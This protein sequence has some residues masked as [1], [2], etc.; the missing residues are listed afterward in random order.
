MTTVVSGVDDYSMFLVLPATIFLHL[1]LSQLILADRQK[2][3]LIIVFAIGIYYGLLVFYVRPL[4]NFLR[5]NVYVGKD[6]RYP[7]GIQTEWCDRA[8]QLSYLY[9]MEEQVT[10]CYTAA[11]SQQCDNNLCEKIKEGYGRKG[12]LS[13]L[14]WQRKSGKC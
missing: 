14:Q 2:V 4:Q 6:R 13:N 8:R 12:C 7:P 1:I 11:A 10:I 5:D 9:P 3:F